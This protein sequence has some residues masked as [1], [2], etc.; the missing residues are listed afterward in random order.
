MIDFYSSSVLGTT[1]T[2]IK[3]PKTR[4]LVVQDKRVLKKYLRLVKEFDR[5]HN[6]YMKLHALINKYG[7]ISD[8][9][10][11]KELNKIDEIKCQGMTFAEKRCCK[12]FK[13]TVEFSPE[14]STFRDKWQ[15]WKSLKTFI[16]KNKGSETGICRLAKRCNIRDLFNIDFATIIDNEIYSRNEYFSL[17]KSSGWL[18]NSF[19]RSED[20]S[21]SI[22]P[23][24]ARIKTEKMRRIRRKIS[25]KCGKIRMKTITE[26]EVSVGEEIIRYHSRDEVEKALAVCITKRFQRAHDSPFLQEPVVFQVGLLAELEEADK[27]LNGTSNLSIDPYCDFYLKAFA[28]PDAGIRTDYKT[29]HFQGY[30]NKADEKTSSSISGKHFGHYK[31]AA[32]DEELSSFHAMIIETSYNA[33]LPLK[34]WKFA[35]ACLLEK[36]KGVIRV[37]KLRAILLLEADFNGANKTFFGSR[38][39][40][41]LKIS[42]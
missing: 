34:R 33:G 14:L 23:G 24:T 31:A 42:K 25:S 29:H 27:I 8:E 3:K 15:L 17:K 30:W 13:G 9:L 6:I 10:F 41:R 40:S 7:S 32:K 36:I 26:V 22:I 11:Q 21:K 35:L 16:E 38:M 19:L 1:L 5:K 28:H 2:T 18:R 39:V 20:Q 12:L 4:R 37:D